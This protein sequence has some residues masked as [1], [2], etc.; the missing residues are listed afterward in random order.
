MVEHVVLSCAGAALAPRGYS[1]AP[2]SSPEFC[3]TGA[4][5]VQLEVCTGDPG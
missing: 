2:G 1:G 5:G 4:E 3:H